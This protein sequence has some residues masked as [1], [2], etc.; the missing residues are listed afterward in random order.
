MLNYP[1][2]STTIL[3]T[4]ESRPVE[5]WLAAEQSE[6]EE[7]ADI[8]SSALWTFADVHWPDLFINEVD[9]FPEFEQNGAAQI[10]IATTFWPLPGTGEVVHHSDQFSHSPEQGWQILTSE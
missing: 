4:L 1:E 9:I 7:L 3:E 8:L 2:P 6:A 10:D 5:H